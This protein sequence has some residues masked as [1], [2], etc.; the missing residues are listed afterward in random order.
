MEE[1][2]KKLKDIQ[3]RTALYDDM[4]NKLDTIEITPEDYRFLF[5]EAYLNRRNKKHLETIDDEVNDKN[6]EIKRYR[7]TLEDIRD[8]STGAIRIWAENALE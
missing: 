1:G 2:L 7:N 3:D 5:D 8:A 4:V 6:K